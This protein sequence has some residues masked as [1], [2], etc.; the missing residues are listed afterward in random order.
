MVRQRE[1]GQLLDRSLTILSMVLM[2]LALYFAITLDITRTEYAILFLGLSMTISVL[3]ILQKGSFL[4]L[5]GKWLQVVA[6]FLIALSLVPSIYLFLEYEPLLLIR[7]GAYSTPDYLFGILILIPLLL[8]TLK[9]AGSVLFVLIL[10]FLFYSFFGYIFPGILFH[11]GLSFLRI[12]QI[13]VLELE[14]VHGLILGVIATWVALF[15]LYAGLIRGFGGLEVILK[16]FYHLF[17]RKR[18]L[19]PQIP[20]VT[21]MIFG[22]FSGSPNAN[23]AGTGS[24]TIPL[25]K[26]FGIPP[27]TAGAIEAVASSGGQVMPPIMGA[28]AFL[29]VSF[30]GE[31]YLHIV[32]IGFIPALIFYAGTA[33]ATYWST[34]PFIT[35]SSLSIIDEKDSRLSWQEMG[36]LI[37]MVISVIVLF[38]YLALMMPIMRSVLYGIFAFFIAQVIYE[39]ITIIRGRSLR[40]VARKFSQNLVNGMR[41]AGISAAM[42]GILGGCLGIAIK[43]LT[44]TALGPKLSYQLVE[45]SQGILPVMLL[46]ILMLCMIFGMT[47]GGIATYVIVA[48]VVSIPL[49]EF[50]IDPIITHFMIFYLGSA[51]LVT[52]PVAGAALVASTISGSPYMTTAWQAMKLGIPLF[53]LPLAFA[54]YPELLTFN[55][56]TPLAIALVTV[57]VIGIAYGSH[58]PERGWKIIVKR[59]FCFIAS[60]FALFHPNAIFQISAAVIIVLLLTYSPLLQRLRHDFS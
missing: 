49:I 23:V 59:V 5:K 37:P 1:R 3:T 6:F 28:I 13:D 60:G 48:S 2:G 54:I 10:F 56:K 4:K 33:A 18:Y 43:A 34:K 39:L 8:L 22:S 38:T 45:I 58:T 21:S 31:S 52:P 46:L 17:K 40:S 47:A 14:A 11:S 12:I 16:L 29:M 9:E 26:S 25:L 7:A 42:I 51:A 44:V 55:S 24:F 30:L 36:K 32:A 35:I 27:K 50:G 20:V 19:I 57:G 53:I 15:L 41:S